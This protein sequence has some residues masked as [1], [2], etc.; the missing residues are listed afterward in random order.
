MDRLAAAHDVA[1]QMIDT[2]GLPVHLGLTP[3]GGS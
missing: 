2:N 1:V 3:G